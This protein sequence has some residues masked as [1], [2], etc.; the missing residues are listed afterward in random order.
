MKFKAAFYTRGN[1]DPLE[2]EWVDGQLSGDIESVGVVTIALDAWK[3]SR[4]SV[5]L[6]PTGPFFYG[7]EMVDEPFGFIAFM[8]SAFPE[9][10]IE[11]SGELPELTQRH[12]EGVVY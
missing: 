6:T 5:A 2:I 1:P 8:D 3:Q 12:E 9:P 11:W 4:R 10:E 7:N